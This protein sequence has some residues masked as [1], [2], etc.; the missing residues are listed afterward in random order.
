MSFSSIYLFIFIK[1][2][3]HQSNLNKHCTGLVNICHNVNITLQTFISCLVY[4]GNLTYQH[5]EN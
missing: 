3:P 2:N 4:K 1:Q 5:N